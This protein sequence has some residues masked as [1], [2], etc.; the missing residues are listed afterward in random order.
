MGSGDT[1]TTQLDELFM[2]EK[3]MK[4]PL[5]P[6]GAF[7]TAGVLSAGLISFRNGNYQ[8]SQKLMRARVLV[9]AGTVA[10]M[11]GTAVYYGKF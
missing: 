11:V 3:S 7:A 2:P 6:L 9:Q 5:V 8:L 10:L 1:D 4:N